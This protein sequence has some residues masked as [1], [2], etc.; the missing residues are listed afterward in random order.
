MTVQSAVCQSYQPL[1]VIVVDNS[2]TDA[3]SEEIPKR[4]SESVRYVR[5]PNKDCAGA[6]NTGFAL[7]RGEFIQFLSGDDVLAPGKIQRQ[8]DVFR[9]DPTL[10]IVYGEIRRFQTMDGVADWADVTTEPEEDMLKRFLSSGAE[11][12]TL[13]TLGVLFSRRALEKVGSWDES[14]YI[15]DTDYFLRAAW[16]G[17]RFGHCPGVPMGFRRIRFDQKTKN[18]LAMERGREVLWQKTLN[19]LD[20]EPYRSLAAKI[21]ARHRFWMA[22]RRNQMSRWQALAKLANSRHTS[23]DAVPLSLYTAGLAAIFVPGARRLALS[24]SL[25]SITKAWRRSGA[26]D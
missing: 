13:N 21:L 17:C 8:V 22:V 7:C 4:F 24:D 25:R 10:D 3:T 26:V 18:V 11:W 2:S 5:Q 16:A 9:S 14:L 12:N 15:E 20:R 6:H 1:E 23:P 19:Y